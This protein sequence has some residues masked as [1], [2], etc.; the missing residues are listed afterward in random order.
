M[1]TSLNAMETCEKC[2]ASFDR[3]ATPVEV[4]TT[5]ILCAPCTALRAAEKARKHAAGSSAPAPAVTAK[6]ALA[7]VPVPAKPPPSSTSRTPVPLAKPMAKPVTPPAPAASTRPASVPTPAKEPEPVSEKRVAASPAKPAPRS[8]AS[9]KAKPARASELDKEQLAKQKNRVVVMGYVVSLV[10]MVVAAVVVWQVMSKKNAQA[11][12]I[13][14]AQKLVSDFK[15]T[16][17]EMDLSTEESALAAAKYGDDNREIWEN[18]DD[19]AAETT[20]RLARAHTNAKLFKERREL[21]AR[22]GAIETAFGSPSTLQPNDVVE[23]RRSLDEIEPK[24]TAAPELLLRVATLRASADQLYAERL[25]EDARTSAAAGPTRETL[26][27]FQRAEDEIRVL[28]EKAKKDKNTAQYDLFEP[29]YKSALSESDAAVALVFTPAEIEKAP[30]RDLLADQERANWIA[31]GAKGFEWRLENGEMHV[32]GPDEDAEGIPI[33]SIGDAEKWCD[34]VGEMEFT[35]TKG[36]T[37][38]FFRLGLGS[39]AVDAAIAPQLLSTQAASN[40]LVAGELNKV[41]FSL[42]GSTY[43]YELQGFDPDTNKGQPIG[44]TRTRK[45]ALAFEFQPKSNKA[46]LRITKLRVK[47]LRFGD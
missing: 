22:I 18:N 26:Q 19:I 44:W 20:S 16:F 28:L 12:E 15:N 35:L 2:G 11:E 3:S 45:G 1:G 8:A 43:Y 47:L 46:D 40:P 13:A 5:R 9:K 38:L 32:I 24:V 23:A 27:K 14:A 21:T 4:T 30:W 37:S 33:L 41:N 7:A 10:L 34:F 29:L 25:L 39:N 42:V 6:P 36:E 31:P 17:F